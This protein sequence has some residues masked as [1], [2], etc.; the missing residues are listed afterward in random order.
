MPKNTITLDLGDIALDGFADYLE[1]LAPFYSSDP[2]TRETLKGL[3]SQ[4]REQ[5]PRPPLPEPVQWC[6]VQ[7]DAPG[8]HY[9]WVFVHDCAEPERPWT[10]IGSKGYVARWTWSM[11]TRPVIL[12]PFSRKQWDL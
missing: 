10:R 6:V 11:L 2:V 7:E 4:V 12:W 3:V 5:I 9:G 8:P 1:R